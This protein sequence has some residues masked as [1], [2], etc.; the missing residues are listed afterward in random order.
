MIFFG[1]QQHYICIC[2]DPAEIR[3]RESNHNSRVVDAAPV[4]ADV[5]TDWSPEA[6]KNIKEKPNETDRE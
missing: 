2:S 5:R 4:S 1:F 3:Q 6:L